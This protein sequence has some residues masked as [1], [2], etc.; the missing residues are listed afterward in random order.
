MSVY[1]YS[2]VFNFVSGSGNA[3]PRQ[4][5]SG[6]TESFISP[7]SPTGTGLTM[8]RALATARAAL[9]PQGANMTG[10]RYQEI[11]KVVNNVYQNGAAATSNFNLPG[12]TSSAGVPN[13]SDVPSMSLLINLRSSNYTNIRRYRMACVP[14]VQATAGEY[15]PQPGPVVLGNQLP[16][17]QSFLSTYLALLNGG[18][19]FR[20]SDSSTAQIAIQGV[21]ANG[22]ITVPA[23]TALNVGAR[24]KVKGL[25]NIYNQSVSGGIYY[26]LAN[27]AGT[28]NTYILKGWTNGIVY[29]GIVQQYTL[30]YPMIACGLSDVSRIVTRKVGRPFLVTHGRKSRKKKQIPII[31]GATA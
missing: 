16:G 12:A 23:G 6:W 30:I 17:Y 8:A 4:I 7:N 27:P 18:W 29:F 5:A 13:L 10:I 22:L 25:K 3:N 26:V 15:T 19:Q 24:Y 28:A 20:A 14:D 21:A 9:L 11:D 2:M 31:P 1:K